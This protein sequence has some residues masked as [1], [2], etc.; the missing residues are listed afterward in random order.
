MLTNDPKDKWANNETTN[1]LY[2]DD[3]FDYE[4]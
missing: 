3:D 2:Y 1:E 4:C